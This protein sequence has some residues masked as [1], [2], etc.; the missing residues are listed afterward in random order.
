MRLYKC[1]TAM[2]L[3][4]A[5]CFAVNVTAKNKKVGKMYVYGIATSFNDST[6]YFTSI[7]S[8]D[9]VATVGKTSIL[10][11]KQEYSY[12]LKNYFQNIGEPHRTCVTVNGKNRAK[13]EKSYLKLKQKYAKKY[14]FTVKNLDEAN[15]RYERVV[16]AQ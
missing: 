5:V 8:I 9:S 10:A 4:V 7:Q 14:N 13:L 1:L 3:I 2:I 16:M 15:F 11:D 12:Q 6:A